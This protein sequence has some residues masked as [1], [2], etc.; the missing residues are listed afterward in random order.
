[1]ELALYSIWQIDLRSSA[2][3]DLYICKEY[4]IQPNVIEKFPFYRYEW[5][6]EDIK[7]LIKK[8]E[9]ERKKREKERQTYKPP[10]TPS[11]PKVSIPRIR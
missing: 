1:M 5:M 3:N 6:I 9:E 7:E 10:K 11:I 2:R 4:G 8:E